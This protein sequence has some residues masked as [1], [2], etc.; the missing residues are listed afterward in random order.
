MSAPARTM[1]VSDSI[2]TLSRSTQPL[3][4]AASI[5]ENSPETWYAATGTSTSARTSEITSW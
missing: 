2:I 1:P 3:A 5:S 4:A